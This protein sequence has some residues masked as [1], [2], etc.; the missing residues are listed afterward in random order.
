VPAATPL[1]A[2]ERRETPRDA[3]NGHSRNEEAARAGPITAK[4]F[5]VPKT[6]VDRGGITRAENLKRYG[7]DEDIEYWPPVA[8]AAWMSMRRWCGRSCERALPVRDAGATAR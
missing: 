3:T 6:W 4:E 8:A 5:E 2:A 7:E 1:T